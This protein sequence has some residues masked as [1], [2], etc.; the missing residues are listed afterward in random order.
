MK[1]HKCDSINI[2][3]KTIKIRKPFSRPNTILYHQQF[4]I[5]KDAEDLNILIW[6]L[7]SSI[8][9]FLK[10]NLQRH[11]T[12]SFV[13]SR[14]HKFP[15]KR[16]KK[17]LMTISLN[18]K[19]KRKGKRTC[20]SALS[21]IARYKKASSSMI[22]RSAVNWISIKVQTGNGG[23]LRLIVSNDPSNFT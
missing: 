15:L 4:L 8:W 19:I 17:W 5:E 23:W 6:L 10:E 1:L 20:Q 11:K 21:F 3:L 9:T 12:K 7:F 13:N 18:Q 2:N 14:Y 22:A 16:E